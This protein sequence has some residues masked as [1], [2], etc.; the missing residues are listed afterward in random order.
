MPTVNPIIRAVAVKDTQVYVVSIKGHDKHAQ[1]LQRREGEVYVH[2]LNTDKRLD[3]W[4]SEG[5]VKPV[6]EHASASSSS[7]PANGRKRKRDETRRLIASS[8][9][10][11]YRSVDFALD[12]DDLA[13][14]QVEVSMTEE[15]YDIQH[16]K[17][18][19]A[20]RNFDKV[21]FGHW[22]MKTWY[23][24]PYPLTESEIDEP[25]SQPSTSSQAPRIPGVHKTTVRSHGRTSDLLAGGLRRTQGS[26]ERSILWVCDRCFKY[27]A[28]GP[29]WDVH[30]KKCV[31]NHPPGRKVYQR[32]A[33]TIWE[34]DGA[35]DKLYC[36]N[37]S[38]FGKLFI[39]IKTLFFDCDNFLF[40]IMTDA[41]SQRDHVLGFFSKEKVSYDDY[42]LACI[43]T[44]P[45]YQRKGYGMLMIEFSYE[46]SRRAGKV[47]TP[48]RPLSD[49]GLRSYLTYWVSTLIRY[50]RRLLSVIP[51]EN[52]AIISRRMPDLSL[53]RSPSRDSEEGVQKIKRKK[54]AKGWEGE[55]TD[56][57][58]AVAPLSIMDDELSTSMRTIE[59]V[60]NP[61]GSATS[62]AI[63]R[64]TLENIAKATNLRVEDAAF[65]LNECGLLTRRYKGNGSGH[66]NGNGNA[67]GRR[68]EVEEVIMVSREMIE[69]VAKERQVKRTCMDLVHV[70]L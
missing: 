64:C 50:F 13:E 10:T 21:N 47:G 60:A 52:S 41:D 15:D 65:A 38:L 45:P 4:V 57:S 18:I 54:I 2:Y 36:Q 68:Q 7:H 17:Q 28:D 44:L 58:V 22:Q 26:G 59:T 3:E 5:A 63:I 69:A 37:L 31:R 29:T 48:E 23:F 53:T 25:T 24:S 8:S 67:N 27:M 62:H 56:P 34:V 51:P 16:H 46:L 42:N 32:G 55:M 66:A 30:A 12:D 61:D 33:H 70:L 35:K 9:P 19:T 1:I 43:I 14:I 40:Y 20:Q 39:D 6:E 11:R 49:L